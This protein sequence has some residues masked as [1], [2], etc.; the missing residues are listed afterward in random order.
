MMESDGLVWSLHRPSLDC[1]SILY[2]VL[3]EEMGR[4]T[5]ACRLQRRYVLLAQRSGLGRARQGS[6]V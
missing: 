2:L 4:P 3:K 5:Y 6:M 1:Q